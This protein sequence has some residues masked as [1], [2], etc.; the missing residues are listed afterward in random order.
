MNETQGSAQV[1]VEKKTRGEV[2][3]A[4]VYEQQLGPRDTTLGTVSTSLKRTINTGNFNSV[5]I[6]VS[7][8]L[9]IDPEARAKAEKHAADAILKTRELAATYLKQFKEEAG[10]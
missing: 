1:T 6:S 8:T 9:P 10:V 5:A 4:K 3:D 2:T 7:V